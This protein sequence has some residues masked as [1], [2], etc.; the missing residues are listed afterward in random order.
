MKSIIIIFVTSF[1]LL[2]SLRGQWTIVNEGLKFN[3]VDFINKDTGWLAGGNLIYKTTDGGKN[4]TTFS[5]NNMENIVAIDFFNDS[6]GWAIDHNGIIFKSLDGG[7]N[8]S[9]QKKFVCDL[10]WLEPGTICAVTENVVYAVMHI[11]GCDTLAKIRIFKTSNG[12]SDW[13]SVY[14]FADAVVGDLYFTSACFLNADTGMIVVRNDN[15]EFIRKTFNG[16]I[17]WDEETIPEFFNE[18]YNVK[19]LGNSTMYFLAINNS[20]KYLICKTTNMFG[21]WSVVAEFNYP[22]NDYHFFNNVVVISIMSD[23]IGSNIIMK[24][25][26]GGLT[27]EK[28]GA[29]KLLKYISYEIIFRTEN[30]GYIIG[31]INI[32]SRGQQ[33]FTEIIKSV[34]QGNSWTMLNFNYPLNDVCFINRN[35]GFVIGGMDMPHCRDGSTFL[36]NDGGKTWEVSCNF[37]GAPVFCFLTNDSNGYINTKWGL[38]QIKLYQTQDG[39]DSWLK[40]DWDVG[41]AVITDMFFVNNS[42]GYLTK[43]TEIYKT[44]NSGIS[45]DLNMNNHSCTQYQSDECKNFNSVFFIDDSTGWAVGDGGI[46][47]KYTAL[48]T[49]KKIVS[50]TTLPLNK[51]FFADKNIGWIVGGYRDSY[52]GTGFYPILL[53]TENGGESWFKIENVNYLIHD[54][55]FRNTQEGWAVGEDKNGKGIII[56]TNNSGNNWYVS[57]GNLSGPLKAIQF[58]DGFGWAVGDNGLILKAI[59]STLTGLNES[60]QTFDNYLHIQNYPNPFTTNTVISY[61]LPVI[62]EVELGVYDIMGRKVTTLVNEMQPDGSYEVEWNAE[63]IKPGIFFCELKAGQSRKVIKMVLLK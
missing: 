35:K 27:W 63:G 47:Y 55:Y 53:K 28:A 44:K 29:I 4:W 31:P 7:Q 37:D 3:S 40:N 10:G 58:K 24:S 51:V 52:G 36:T 50:G 62:S 38:E 26:D 16:G 33:I 17:T 15:K 2:V 23:S 6:I 45:W 54:L 39:G 5:E 14:H 8:W 49:W 32:N 1:I 12:G 25:K 41:G 22:I 60:V 61:Q 46:I 18:I 11:Y 42:I 56:V 30:V 57:V 48:E 34:D 21:K 13:V 43:G 19:I 59:D 20:D 9:Q